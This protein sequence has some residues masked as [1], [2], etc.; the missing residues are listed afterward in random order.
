MVATFVSFTALGLPQ[1]KFTASDWGLNCFSTHY[2]LER[3]S[4]NYSFS[5]LSWNFWKSWQ[6]GDAMLKSWPF[7]SFLKFK[8]VTQKLSGGS[9]L[10]WMLCILTELFFQP[11]PLDFNLQGNLLIGWQWYHKQRIISEQVYYF[12][13]FHFWLCTLNYYYTW[14]I[15]LLCICTFSA[16][17]KQIPAFNSKQS[18]QIMWIRK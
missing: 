7:S 10:E 6:N 2:L 17:N 8:P 18:R 16:E 12:R 11:L 4:Y 1:S 14:Y 15:K 3:N 5:E 9:I 13:F